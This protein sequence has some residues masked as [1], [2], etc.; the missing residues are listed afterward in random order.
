[1]IDT[2]ISVGNIA[3]ILMLAGAI[4]VFVFGLQRRIDTLATQIEFMGKEVERLG[5]VVSIQAVQSSR[6]DRVEDD[7]REL[8]HGEGFVLKNWRAPERPAG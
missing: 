8:R 3:Q 2:T 6:L 4:I 1:M 5:N 7:I